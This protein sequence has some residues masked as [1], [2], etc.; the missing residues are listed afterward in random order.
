LLANYVNKS[1]KLGARPS[2]RGRR[3]A[4]PRGNAFRGRS[5]ATEGLIPIE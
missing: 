2:A 4:P 5:T 1:H 3:L